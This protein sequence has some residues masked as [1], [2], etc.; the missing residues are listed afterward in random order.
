MSSDLNS[1]AE[2]VCVGGQPHFGPW[3]FWLLGWHA[4]LFVQDFGF[5]N[6]LCVD[7]EHRH[8]LVG[9]CYTMITSWKQNDV[10]DLMTL[11]DLLGGQAALAGGAKTGSCLSDLLWNPWETRVSLSASVSESRIHGVEL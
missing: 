4:I 6:S 5:R 11:C 9:S 7:T 8:L 2:R 10:E 1:V 3:W